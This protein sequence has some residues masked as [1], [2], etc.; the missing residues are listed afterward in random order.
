M[1]SSDVVSDESGREFTEVSDV[2]AAESDAGTLAAFERRIRLEESAIRQ[3]FRQ[4]V[5][6]AIIFAFAALTLVLIVRVGPS[7]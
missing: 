7:S 1:R 6:L 5:A 3:R 4:H 2:G